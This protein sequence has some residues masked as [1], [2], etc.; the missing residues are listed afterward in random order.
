[1]SHL[2]FSKLISAAALAIAFVVLPAIAGSSVASA[3]DRFYRGRD[4]GRERGYCDDDL[5]DHQRRERGHQIRHERNERET[6]RRHQ[7]EEYYRY[8]DS[9]ELRHHQQ[10]ERQELREHQRDEREDLHD[11]QHAERRDDYYNPQATTGKAVG[12]TAA[13]AGIGAL[14]GALI[15]GGKGAAIGALIGGA[16]GYIYHEQKVNNQNDRWRR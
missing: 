16:G 6:L 5:R 7:E 4:F 12:R 8:G 15:G 11:H 3:Q 14:A 10:H 1:M 13:G 9:D 2:G